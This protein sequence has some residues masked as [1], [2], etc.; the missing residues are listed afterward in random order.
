MPYGYLGTQP[1]QTVKNTGVLSV[2]EAAELQSQGKLGGSLEFIEEK[3]ISAV[4][5][6]IF[7]D[8]KETVY[9]V[10]YM[11]VNN[12]QASDDSQFPAVRF[13]ESGVEESGNV[14]QYAVQYG[15]AD[16]TFGVSQAGGTNF[17]TAGATTGNQANEQSNSYCYFYN[18]GNSSKYSFQTLHTTITSN[19]TTYTFSFGGGVLPQASIVDQI[20]LFVLSGTFSA[21]AKL[22]GVKQI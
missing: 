18:L 6:A 1:N 7:T 9:D 8:I 2:T 19:T 10:H 13:F 14:Y 20:K 15:R 21:T 22:Y 11:T 5:L 4:S 16:G 3:S 12:F 17:L